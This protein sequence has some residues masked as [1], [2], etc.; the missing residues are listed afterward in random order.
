MAQSNAV[1]QGVRM[2]NLI[3][4]KTPAAD[5]HRRRYAA[6]AGP[7]RI[8][9]GLYN[10]AGEK[11]GDLSFKAGD[12]LHLL[13]TEETW[14]K[15]HHVGKPD[16][17]GVFPRNYVAVEGSQDA[18]LHGPQRAQV[19]QEGNAAA[20]NCC[21]IFRKVAQAA[22][23][24]VLS[25]FLGWAW[26]LSGLTIAEYPTFA[27]HLRYGQLGFAARR[28]IDFNSWPNSSLTMHQLFGFISDS[29]PVLV[30]G[31]YPLDSKNLGW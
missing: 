13:E 22:I 19:M 21:A 14:W 15:G 9:R 4:L 26:M 1:A 10:F 6:V 31:G 5:L 20:E 18:A 28:P 30:P 29:T 3:G 12:R 16:K 17:V 23:F 25:V 27:F 11:T 2:R 24:S 7:K 8:A